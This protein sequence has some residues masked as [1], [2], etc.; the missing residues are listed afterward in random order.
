M[1]IHK[2]QRRYQWLWILCG[3]VG[4][5]FPVETI[6]QQTVPL[7]NSVLDGTVID[8][9]TKEPLAGATIDIAGITH[10]T[11][12]DEN[13]KFRFVTGQKFPYTLIVT[14][15]GYKTINIVAD[16][17]PIT[18]A[19]E[20]DATLLEDVVVV[21]YGT[22]SRR[23]LV[24]S[25]ST[26][27]ADE[28]KQIP[29][30]SFDA[31]LQGKAAGLQ[32][33]SNTGVP[34]EGIFIRVRGTT[35][36]N[37]NNDPL[38]I[39]D[40]I[41]LN[42]TS[43]Q[44]V[45]TG[46]KETSPIADINPSDIESIEVLKDAS[47]TAIYGARGANGV[48]I[49]TTKRGSFNT[50]PVIGFN[51]TH[52]WAHAPK[53]WDIA[54][55]PENAAL[56]NESWIN[57]GI[58]NPALNQTYENRPFRPV[59]EGGRGTPEE[60]ETYDRLG[61]VF[62][63]AQLQNYDLTLQG[64]NNS[65]RYY[66][67]AGYNRQ[68]SIMQPVYFERSSFKLNLDQQISDRV[69]IG[70]SNGVSRTFRNQARAGDG[71]QGGMFQTALLVATYLPK[72]N[73]DGTPAKWGPWDNLD[74]LLNN[75]DVT[76][77]NLRYIGNIHADVEILP[78][79]KFRTSFGVDYNNYEEAEYWNSLTLIG[80]P[81]TNGRATSAISQNSTW[82]TEQTLTY[83]KNWGQHR[84]GA[85]IGNSL[86]GDIRKTTSAEGTDFANDSFK[87]IASA[88][89][90]ISNQFWT[91]SKLASFFSRVD[92]NYAGK[93]YIEVAA[94]ADGSSRFGGNNKWG[95]FPSVGVSWRAKAESFLADVDV[96]DDLKLRASYG[97]AG[98]Q[99][100]GDFAARGLW[101]GG[102]GYPDIVGGGDKPGTAP[103]QLANRDLKWERTRQVN[104]G[105]DI[106]LLRQRLNI[107]FNL[108]HKHTKDALLQLPLPST[109][110][111]GSY[112]S[113][114][115]EIINKGYEIGIQAVNIRHENF[116]WQ[117]SFNLSGNTNHIKKLNAPINVY[118]RDWI[119]MQEGYPMYS[120]WLYNQL[121][122]D[123]S[124]G[125]AVFEDVNGDGQITVADRQIMGNALPDFY[126][127]ITNNFTYRSWDLG[128]L[129][130]FQYGNDVY[131]M[132]EFFDMAGGT[133]P[134][135]FAIANSTKRWQ[136]PGDVTDVPRFTT[137][138]N[139]YRL[140]QNSR[141]LE[142]GSFLRLQ[143]LTLGY[144]LPNRIAERIKSKSLRVYL[145]GS[146]LW[147]LT[148]Y[149]GLDP[150]SNVSNGQNVQGL[151]F[152]TPPQPRTIQLGIQLSI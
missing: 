150:E 11:K 17:S 147:L 6:A 14:Y 139:N 135:R 72:N 96:I 115:G 143:S 28:T 114:E 35:S 5:T 45:S 80:A 88:A 137:V 34:G 69:Q 59:E 151:D 40:G 49:V 70:L 152:G 122:V 99:N 146:N 15:I 48:V 7:V 56:L 129:F 130:T 8:A 58:D 81:P 27:K 65:T 142:D 109:T 62:R 50:K 102:A 32:I 145:V 104:V 9:A 106:S 63:T 90:R 71:P 44:T 82:L 112:Y 105:L 52:G 30:G 75:Y 42:N 19:L 91:Q 79:L 113:N 116:Q 111:F 87:L 128:V 100:I 125:D 74:V 22:Q 26:I 134:D 140:E 77:A 93:Y 16:G 117:T 119:R 131:N 38:Y 4:L 12:T 144:T 13:G 36:I 2:I 92:Y 136:K 133:R 10:S 33:S 101:S 54:S 64:G 47:A 149:S 46:G 103:Q 110:G 1:I 78:D 141:L 51:A 132:N 148:R 24:G 138:G 76:T 41:F 25:V 107:E 37:A 83:R 61:D 84:F 23:D 21:G 60:Q 97:L 123:P 121:Y 18:I 57:S 67:G 124:T 68:E 66:I 20:Q 31:Q 89:N 95:Y 108:Y 43:L 118:S 127:G 94:R 55:G 53:I 39:V 85:L 98:N 3:F 126:G 86:Q 29:V 120:F 73:P